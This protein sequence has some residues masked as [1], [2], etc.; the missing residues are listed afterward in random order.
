MNLN[1]PID[2]RAANTRCLRRLTQKPASLRLVCFPNAGAGASLFRRWTTLFSDGIELHTIQLPGREDR[3]SQRPFRRLIDAATSVA[4]ELA[5]M[6]DKPMVLF[7]H[8]MGAILAY[9]TARLLDQMRSR[10]VAGLIMSGHGA[11]S[12]Q[13]PTQRCRY[14][15]GDDELL[16]DLHRLNGTPAELL[17]DRALMAAYLPTLRADYEV[18][19]TYQWAPGTHL[20]C[21][22]IAYSGLQDREVTPA[23]VAGWE[24]MT[25]GSY[26]ER[27]F[28]GEHFYLFD[29]QHSVLPTLVQDVMRLTD[30]NQDG[31]D[32]AARR[33]AGYIAK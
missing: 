32:H 30:I 18:L 9:E 16:A 1:Q 21:P 24:Q 17:A 8:S 20:S 2:S 26:V 11:P 31:S 25:T 29:Y 19:D 22:I 27:W 3:F 5:P 28:E 12:L 15:S 7:G 4:G 13:S 33:L 6:I 10:P 23:T 14:D